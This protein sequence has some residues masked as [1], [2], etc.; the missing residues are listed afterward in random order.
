MSQYFGKVLVNKA[1][2]EPLDKFGKKLRIGQKVIYM[3]SS[4]YKGRGDIGHGVIVGFNRYVKIVVD[5]WANNQNFVHSV[6][7]GFNSPDYQNDKRRTYQKEESLGFKHGNH[8]DVSSSFLIG[9]S[10]RFMDGWLDGT[11]RE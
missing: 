7:E 8:D 2:V 11:I 10:D 9:V 3:K 1:G 6:V 5:D 4:Q